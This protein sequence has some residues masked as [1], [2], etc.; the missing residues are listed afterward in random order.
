VQ[1]NGQLGW[2]PATPSALYYNTRPDDVAALYTHF[3]CAV[4]LAAVPMDAAA[5]IGAINLW[6]GTLGTHPWA[7]CEIHIGAAT[8][9]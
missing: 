5:P 2:Y 7:W 1:S 9:Y 4:A 8:W 6:Q 3:N